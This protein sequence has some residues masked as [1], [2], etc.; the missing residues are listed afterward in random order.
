MKLFVCENPVTFKNPYDGKIYTVPCGKCNTCAK[1]KSL[2]WVEKLESERKAHPYCT[3]ITLTYNDEHLP[4]FVLFGKN[5]FVDPDTGELVDID[6]ET[7]RES[8]EYLKNR[9]YCVSH[10]CKEHLQRFIKKLRAKTAF[11]ETDE[12]KKIVRYI[13]VAE[14]GPEHHRVHYHGILYYDSPWLARN[15]KK[16]VTSSWS[17]DNR[18]SDNTS[19]GFVKVQHVQSSAA[20]YTAGYLYCSNDLPPIYQLKPLQ[21][22]K[23]FSKHPPLGS[24][25]FEQEKV[26][27][28][29]VN[30]ITRIPQYSVRTGD[31]NIVPLPSSLK[32]R[33]FPKIRGFGT[34]TH[35]DR[36]R[37]YGFVHERQSEI[38][39][40][41]GFVNYIKKMSAK[42]IN[43]LGSTLY[44]YL[45]EMVDHVEDPDEL[46]D[47]CHWLK[48]PERLRAHRFYSICNRVSY[49]IITL[50]ISSVDE[51]VTYI[52]N[53]YQNCERQNLLDQYEMES[54]FADDVRQLLFID[55]NFV[56]N[57]RKKDYPYD[58]V[59]SLILSGYA[60]DGKFEYDL[61]D[62]S[63][64]ADMCSRSLKYKMDNVKTKK[65]NESQVIL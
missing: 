51:Y 58:E 37:L 62:C 44:C 45:L 17:L 54:Q 18:D 34:F 64:F 4:K 5:H 35:A 42:E 39:Y 21:P 15:I 48:S 29:L 36:V 28:I 49:N 22:L 55:G 50:G 16:V 7:Y 47:V 9:D 63:Q 33:L 14:Y 26:R 10:P 11:Y 30:G 24:L 31:T 65:R 38:Y 52:E 61:M 32:N 20:S 41:G 40:F 43:S 46:F 25:C 23:L 60:I 2:Y 3:F 8:F 56:D 59:T 19:L 1:N 27:E 57:L 13:L 12:H 53:Y 6:S